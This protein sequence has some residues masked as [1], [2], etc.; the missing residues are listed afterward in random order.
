MLK[1]ISLLL[2]FI[3][4][5]TFAQTDTT[6]GFTIKG[7]ISSQ[8]N[9]PV[10]FA[11]VSA[12][13][14]NSETDT[15]IISV[16]STETGAFELKVKTKGN[17][18][19]RIINDGYNDFSKIITIENNTDLG[20]IKMSENVTVL[21]EVVM[22][23]EKP[24]AKLNID[25]RTFEVAN[26]LNAVGGTAETV[27]KNIPSVTI[28]N[29]G[30]AQL[31]N[32]SATIYVDG[33][34]TQLALNQIPA[35]QLESVELITNPSSKYEA[36]ASKGIIN[37][38]LKKTKKPGYNG[39]VSAGIGT[40][41]RYNGMAMLEYSQ[42]KWGFNFM[43]N[44]DTKKVP[45]PNTVT[46]DV[47]TDNV[48]YNRYNQNTDF[49]MNHEFQNGRL[50]FDYRPN[51]KNTISVAGNFVHGQFNSNSSQ[52]YEFKNDSGAI[53]NYGNRTTTPRNSFTNAGVDLDWKKSFAKKGKTLSLTTN[54]SRLTG[55]NAA[56]WLTTSYNQDQTVTSGYPVKN[57]IDGNNIGNQFTGQLDFVQPANDSSKFEMGLRSQTNIRDQGYY[58]YKV[59]NATNQYNI[60]SANTQDATITQTV[61]AA[62]ITYTT[63]LKHQIELQAGLRFEQSGLK[64]SSKIAGIENFGYDFPSS[65]NGNIWKTLFPSIAMTKQINKNSE[66]GISYSRK[67][68]RPNWRQISV[69]IMANDRQ[70][71][72]RGNPALQPEFINNLEANYNRHWRK[73]DWLSSAY[74]AYTENTINSY[75]TS[76]ESDPSVLLTTFRNAKAEIRSGLDNTLT[77]SIGKNLKIM[78]NLNVFNI[79]LNTDTNTV[80]SWAHNE[81]LNVTYKLPYNFT[82][83][84][85]FNNK[86][87]QPQLQGY[88]SAIRTFDLS[89]RKGFLNNKLNAVLALND[90]FNSGKQYTIFK[91]GSVYQTSMQR[92]DIRH[93]KL[94]IQYM[95]GNSQNGGDNKR[96]PK[97][98]AAPS[99][100]DMDMG[101]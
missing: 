51:P 88:K 96:K 1:K 4:Y 21:K 86:S 95:F 63:K 27:L 71:I 41:N 26:N 13:N 79:Q 34:P 43:Y 47:S 53:T 25:K 72:S 33:K 52:Y 23:D 17:Y 94:T 8:N 59:D 30:N 24:Q 73:A 11:V 98:G 58:F 35:G 83:Q 64:G 84:A 60:D 45:L 16:E 70:N 82:V 38:V 65:K 89:V 29:D 2:T 85:N 6:L 18:K 75:T 69:G 19:L 74:L 76:L 54:Y 31:R 39:M 61:N 7:L 56:N 44:Y 101:E 12:Q 20:I 36:A 55:S 14:T 22:V 87:K 90:V 57:V 67:I 46:K 99:S 81:K 66:F 40:N 93:V 32:A 49:V 62:Y 42:K 97:K 77:Y 3:V 80:N 28:D 92:R 5:S 9:D 100:G 78:G 15:T 50:G 91:E 37:L 48:F 68:G 10:G